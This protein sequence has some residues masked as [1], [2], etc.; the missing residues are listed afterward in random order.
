MDKYYA[1]FLTIIPP[2][3]K[4]RTGGFALLLWMLYWLAVYYLGLKPLPAA[5]TAIV[6]GFIGYVTGLGNGH[7]KGKLELENRSH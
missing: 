2:K 1:A 4:A 5:A 7:K 3:Y 6:S